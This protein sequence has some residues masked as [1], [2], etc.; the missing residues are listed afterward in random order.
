MSF[1]AD[2]VRYTAVAAA[3][4][5]AI[6]YYLI[7]LGVLYIGKSTRDTGPDLFGFGAMAGSAFVVAAIL[8]Y[9]FRSRIVLVAIGLLQVLVIVGYFA[10]AD[11]RSPSFEMWG[12]HVKA[13]QVV[14]LAAVAW[15]LVRGAQARSIA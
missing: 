9:L 4:A 8:L 10:M 3:A 5:A 2:H 14:V 11:I 7:G 12:L 15:L 13:C 6:L 1:R